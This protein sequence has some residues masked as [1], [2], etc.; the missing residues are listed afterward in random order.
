[1][2]LLHFEQ[3]GRP[4]SAQQYVTTLEVAEMVAV[5]EIWQ[6]LGCYFTTTRAEWSARECRAM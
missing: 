3:L 5:H 1:M 2:P 6:D 4:G